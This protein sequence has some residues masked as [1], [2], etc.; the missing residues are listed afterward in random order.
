VF[1]L[2]L[3]EHN[4]RIRRHFEGLAESY[5][6]WKAQNRYYHAYLMRWCRSVLPPGA[7]VL[8]V[9]S[10]RG[11]VLAA[12]EPRVGLGIDLSG[13]MVRRAR[14]EHPHLEFRQEAI[15]AF[16]GDASFDAALLINTLEYA[17]DV[18]LVLDRIHGS[19]RDN[20][21]LLITTAN[22]VWSPIFH[23]ASTLG[24]RV[25]ECARLFVTNEDVVNML[26]LH[27]F[28]VVYKQ[29]T[30]CLPKYVPVLSN[31]LNWVVART[32]FLRFVGSTQLILARK[33]PPS[34]R[35]YSV[36][37]I[38]PCHNERG[39][40]DECVRSVEPFG[41]RTELV[42][43]DDGSS[44]GTAEGIKPELNP[45]IDVRVI[46]YSPNRGKGQAVKAGFDAAR[47]DIV[48][49]LDADLTTHPK[50]LGP[51][52]EAF[53]TGR[54]EFVNCTRLVYPMQDRAMK[55]ANFVG[56]K[57][58]TLL[59]SLIM[60]ARVSDTLCGTKAMFRRDYQHMTMGRDPWGDYDLLFGAAQLRLVIRE[61]PVHYR[62]RVAGV[63]KMRA[64]RHMV[65]LL[66]MLGYGFLQVQLMR[67]I[68]G[69]QPDALEEMPS[70][71][72]VGDK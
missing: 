17:Y 33:T 10:G 2:R 66:R 42:F 39:N 71:V 8:E 6:R 50:E 22:P 12:V 60:G 28:E 55:F 4:E 21:R 59:V 34:R 9:G 35:E 54:A 69:P 65:N 7:R 72:S 47:G 30:L 56:N 46:S 63:S 25:P 62:E 37:L 1:T 38:V 36:S 44:D 24:W 14:E 64:F 31:G 68:A 51:I 49:V 18:G 52:Y 11:D 32:P 20:G 41:T 26:R 53:A 40:V 5:L 43:V 23:L 29:T 16:E 70:R 61:L 15:E 57:V 58:F 45:A 3:S 48:M 13:E 27:G 19:L 67:P